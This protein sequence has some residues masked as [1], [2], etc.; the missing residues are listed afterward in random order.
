MT[1]RAR[2]IRFEL[3]KLGSAVARGHLDAR[4]IEVLRALIDHAEAA[5]PRRLGL[6]GARRDLKVAGTQL[7]DLA[8][9][10]Q[11]T[12]LDA[13]SFDRLPRHLKDR[14]ETRMGNL[15]KRLCE[16]K[17]KAQAQPADSKKK[18]FSDTAFR[19][20]EDHEACLERASRPPI[21]CHIAMVL[22]LIRS[23]LPAHRPPQPLDPRLWKP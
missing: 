9:H 4:D 22:C 18:T 21:W 7:R 15:T 1:G 13:T 20:I 8:R 3:R 17:R 16:A 23:L 10:L 6:G 2:E 12:A 11:G 19:C 5:A 14:I